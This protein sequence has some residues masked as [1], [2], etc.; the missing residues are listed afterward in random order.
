DNQT[1]V[2][3]VTPSP[4]QEV[5]KALV[6]RPPGTLAENPLALMKNRIADCR[7]QLPVKRAECLVGRLVGTA[8]EKNRHSN[9]PPF[10]L[11][12]VKQPRPRERRDRDCDGAVLLRR[13]HGCRARLVMVLQEPHELFLK[14]Q[15]SAEMQPDVFRIAVHA[16]IE[17]LVVAEVESLLLQFPFEVPVSLRDKN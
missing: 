1:P 2:V 7:Q 5:S 12:V 17:P 13:K 6:V 16:V 10:Q 3:S 8:A 14:L 9:A 11:A 4:R 15:R